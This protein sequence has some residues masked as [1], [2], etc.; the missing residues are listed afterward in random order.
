MH[1]GRARNFFLFCGGGR[2]AT[3][4]LPPAYS[5]S[6]VGWSRGG[7]F[8][9]GHRPTRGFA[10]WSSLGGVCSPGPGSTWGFAL[11]LV[12][13]LTLEEFVPAPSPT[14]SFA[15]RS[16][17]RLGPQRGSF[18]VPAPRGVLQPDLQ[19]SLAPR[20]VCSWSWSHSHVEF[21]SPAAPGSCPGGVCFWSLSRSHMRFCSSTCS[22]TWHPEGF[23]PGPGPTQGF[24]PQLAPGSSPE[25]VLLL[26]PVPCRVLHSSLYLGLAPE[27][28][29]PGA[30]L[31]WGFAAQLAPGSRPERGVR[32]VPVPL[33]CGLLHPDLHPSPAPGR[34]G[35]MKWPRPQWGLCP[36]LAP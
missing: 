22:Q 5:W 4:S 33:P 26:L 29:A 13:G 9:T 20:S 10:P 35:A 6:R 18:L 23:T 1:A 14:R 17:A 27:G 25:R 28:F 16:A 3:G 7:R 19:P 36:D 15:A 8:A 11:Q 21:C 34:V 24:A 2:F 31:T 30:G 32:P 12:P